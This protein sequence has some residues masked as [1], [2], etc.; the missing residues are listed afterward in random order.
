[1]QP[2]GRRRGKGGGEKKTTRDC[3]SILEIKTTGE[4]G[5]K[6]EL[7]LKK[8]ARKLSAIVRKERKKVPSR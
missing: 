5:R 1:M 6:K 4:G 3:P 7:D 8:H 2:Y